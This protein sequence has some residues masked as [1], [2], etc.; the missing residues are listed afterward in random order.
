MKKISSFLLAL[1]IMFTLS[2]PVFATGHTSDSLLT[3]EQVLTDLETSHFTRDVTFIPLDTST[4]FTNC[5][6]LKFDSIEEVEI[7]LQDF[8]TCLDESNSI[9][10]DILPI[11]KDGAESDILPL[12]ANSTHNDSV[13]WWAPSVGDVFAWKNIAYTYTVT[14]HKEGYKYVSDITV[15]DS[16]INHL[17][18]ALSWT[19]KYGNAEH[20]GTLEDYAGILGYGDLSA[21]GVWLVGFEIMGFPVGAQINDTWEKSVNFEIS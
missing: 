16:W 13:T 5:E 7:F 17:A 6:L 18:V 14:T 1:A 21:T 4:T 11:T 19:H 3:T 10:G 12:A 2:T 15:T 9:E 20:V 8:I